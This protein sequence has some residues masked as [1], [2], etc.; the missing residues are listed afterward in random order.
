MTDWS[1]AR[2]TIANVAADRLEERFPD[3]TFANQLNHADTASKETDEMWG[4][5]EGAVSDELERRGHKR[6]ES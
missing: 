6:I 3:L 1:E 2:D 5:V 4:E